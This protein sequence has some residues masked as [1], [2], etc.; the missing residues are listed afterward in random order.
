MTSVNVYPPGPKPV[1]EIDLLLLQE[2]ASELLVPVAPLQEAIKV[3]PA[4]EKGVLLGTKYTLIVT[5]LPL[6]VNVALIEELN[7]FDIWVR[8]EKLMNKVAFVIDLDVMTPSISMRSGELSTGV[9][10]PVREM[11]FRVPMLVGP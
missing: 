10:C 11:F 8:F 2:N 3:P 4:V 5:Q 6:P 1:R 9:D 7:N